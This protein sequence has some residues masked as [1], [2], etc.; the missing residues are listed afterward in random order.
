MNV[1]IPIRRDSLKWHVQLLAEGSLTRNS[2]AVALSKWRDFDDQQEGNENMSKE[3][4][5]PFQRFQAVAKGLVKVSKTEVDKKIR[6]QR[7]EKL[8]NRSR[9]DA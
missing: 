9:N 6:D 3:Q 4:K 2:L 7:K 8:K 1:M 5:T